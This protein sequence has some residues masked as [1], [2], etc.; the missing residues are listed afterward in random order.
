MTG[1]RS[2]LAAAL[3]LILATPAI[4]NDSM[5]EL[6][7][8]GLIYVRTDA[9]AMESEDLFISLDEVKVDYIFRNRTD[10]DVESVVA[11]PMPDME[12]NPHANIALPQDMVDNFLGFTATV[13]GQAVEP[14]LD[15]RVFAA[16]VDVTEELKAASVPLFPFGDAVEAAIA[17]LPQA[18]RD[19]WVARGILTIDTYDVGQGMTDHY[20]PTW[21]LKSAYWWRMSF[22]AGQPVRVSHSYAPGVGGSAGL[23]FIDNGRPGGDIHRQY[24]EKYC[25]DASF[26]RAIQKL[27][28]RAGGDYPP[29][30]ESWISY[31]LTT[32]QNWA[33]TIE[34]FRVTI[35][36]GDPSTLVS[37]CGSG[38]K[39]TGPTTFQMTAE[40]FYPSKDLHILLVRKSQ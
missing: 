14:T 13:D 37:F 32:G 26:D 21:T 18:T 24:Q 10:A 19:D 28:Q 29:Y 31:V 9:V 4:A 15:Q 8:G 38:V 25:M 27:I 20:V 22:A 5:A 36:K 40:N 34:K 11:F 33:T 2:F 6:S 12:A 30:Y 35:D 23:S 17:A 7:A 1:K 3:A 16:E 39:K